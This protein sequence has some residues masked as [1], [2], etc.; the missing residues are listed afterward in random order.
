MI[1][2]LNKINFSLGANTQN[3]MMPYILLYYNKI[4]FVIFRS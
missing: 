3:F 4:V 2:L 1:S